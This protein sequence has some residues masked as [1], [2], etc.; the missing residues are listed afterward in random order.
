MPANLNYTMCNMSKQDETSINST[1]S[2]TFK[3]Y[4]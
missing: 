2:N 4:L 3:T 1:I